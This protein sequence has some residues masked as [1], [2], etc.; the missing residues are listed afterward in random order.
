M[1]ENKNQEIV[2]KRSRRRATEKPHGGA[3]KVAFADFTLAMMAFFMV[4]WIYLLGNLV[5]CL[6]TQGGFLDAAVAPLLPR[7][8]AGAAWSAAA[9]G[10][11]GC[12]TVGLYGPHVFASLCIPLCLV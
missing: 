4:M 10:A 11:G 12:G 9:A 7:A 8:A 1:M 6:P 2:I 3:W 5:V